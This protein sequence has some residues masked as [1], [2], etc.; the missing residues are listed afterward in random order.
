MIASPKTSYSSA[1]RG[2]FVQSKFGNQFP[3]LPRISNAEPCMLV[4]PKPSKASLQG[5]LW[6]LKQKFCLDDFRIKGPQQKCFHPSVRVVLSSHLDRLP[7][8]SDLRATFLVQEAQ[9]ESSSCWSKTM[10]DYYSSHSQ[11]PVALDESQDVGCPSEK[12]KP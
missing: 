4:L 12:S 3:M 5:L 2:I 1:L 6:S 8:A 11:I 7:E 9:K 10:W